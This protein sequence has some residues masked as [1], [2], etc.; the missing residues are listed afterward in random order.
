M[1]FV[2]KSII[3]SE[4]RTDVKFDINYLVKVS[5]V[6]SYKNCGKKL[7]VF[8]G[9]ALKVIKNSLY[10]EYDMKMVFI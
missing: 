6:L 3:R 8:H 4:K 5:Q 7:F 10:V 2:F 1:V 9:M